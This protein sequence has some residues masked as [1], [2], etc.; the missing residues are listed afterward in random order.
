MKLGPRE[1]F[2]PSSEF[3]YEDT[4]GVVHRVWSATGRQV[5]AKCGFVMPVSGTLQWSGKPVGCLGC[6]AKRDDDA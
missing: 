1:V 6:I 5:A 2:V 4:D 3:S